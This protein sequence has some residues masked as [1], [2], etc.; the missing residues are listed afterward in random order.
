MPS[1][2][3]ATDWT[4]PEYPSKVRI[5]CPL[6]RIPQ[7]DVPVPPPETRCAPSGE[8]ATAATGRSCPV[9]VC[10]SCPLAASHSLAPR[11]PPESM[12][13]PSGEN[14]T[15]LTQLDV[16]KVRISWPLA[17]SHSFSPPSSGCPKAGGC[18]PGK[19]PPTLT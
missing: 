17:A 11:G 12:R 8:N 15:E 5:S 16:A 10:I 2:E 9:K 7:L 14:A 19:M 1:G 18:R 6:C 4:E 13:V 3:D